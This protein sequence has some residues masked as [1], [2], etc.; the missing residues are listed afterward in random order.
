VIRTCVALAV[1]V[2][3]LPGL[4]AADEASGCGAFKWPIERERAALEGTN[5]PAVSNGDALAYD[6]ASTLRLAP[7]AEARLRYAPQRGPKSA[8]SFAGHFTLAA[9]AKPGAYKVTIASEGWIDVIDNGAFLRPKGF[10]GAVGCAGARK[11]VKFDLPGRP[12][13]IQLSGVRDPEVAV[14]VSPSD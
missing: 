5:K 12:L 13:D 1:L 6:V 4:A 8:Q 3:A 9:P 10:S 11:S 14:M 2:A 7:F